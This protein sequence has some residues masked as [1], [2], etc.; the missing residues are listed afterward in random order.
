MSAGQNP[1]EKIDGLKVA[2]YVGDGVI[3]A[4]AI[5]IAVAVAVI[6]TAGICIYKRHSRNFQGVI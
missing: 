5:A 2:L 3:I 6:V 4:I 1:G